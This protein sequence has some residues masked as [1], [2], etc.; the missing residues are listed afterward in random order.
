MKKTLCSFLVIVLTTLGARSLASEIEQKYAPKYVSSSEDG[1]GPGG[2][3][4]A[5]NGVV[6]VEK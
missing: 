2:N 6:K 1:T 3:G 5:K 4:S